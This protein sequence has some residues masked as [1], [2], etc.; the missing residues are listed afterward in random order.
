MAEIIGRRQWFN[1][2]V[3]DIIGR[4][5]GDYNYG[6][7]RIE[8]GTKQYMKFWGEK[9]ETSY[10]WKSLDSWFITENVRWGKFEPAIDIKAL[11]DKTNRSDLWREAAK[12]LGLSGFPTGDSRG[13]E[14]FF[15]GK[16][17]DPADPMAYLKSLSIKRAMA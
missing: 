11:V 1:V 3:A 17:F 6:R 10:P 9:G 4:I 2:P 5:K 8:K 13:V 16:T 14:K 12:G 7:G 15:D